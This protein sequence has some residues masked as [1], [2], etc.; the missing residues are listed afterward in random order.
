VTMKVIASRLSE[1]RPPCP[2]VKEWS[3]SAWLHTGE[4]DDANPD[5]KR[6][7]VARLPLSQGLKD[8]GPVGIAGRFEVLRRFR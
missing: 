7:P 3:D 5:Y 4:E 6:Q 2:P 1:Y 8:W